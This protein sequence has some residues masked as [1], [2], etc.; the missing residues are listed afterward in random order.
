MNLQAGERVQYLHAGRISAHYLDVLQLHPAMGRNFTETED[1]P[2]GPKSA[3]LSYDLWHNTFGADR[4]L[5]GQVDSSEGRAVHGGR[6]AARGSGDSFECGFV[7]RAPTQ[8]AGRGRRHQLW[9]DYAAARRRQ[10]AGGGLRRSIER[11]QGGRPSAHCGIR[12]RKRL[13][14]LFR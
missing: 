13:S 12:G 3:I 11:G 4:N 7:Y 14:I 6:C 8:P 2:N 10:L 5:L 1:L 9:G